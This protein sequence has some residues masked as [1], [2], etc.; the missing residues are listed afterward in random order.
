MYLST[1]RDLI[2][3]IGGD[4]E[5]RAIFPD[6]AVRISHLGKSNSRLIQRPNPYAAHLYPNPGTVR[7]SSGCLGSF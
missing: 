6:G 7:T 2:R 5:I 4:L 1:L 3:A